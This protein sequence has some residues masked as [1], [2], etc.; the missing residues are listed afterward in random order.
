ML[1][2]LSS[3]PTPLPS[4]R[5]RLYSA[6][7]LR[8]RLYKWKAEMSL[9]RDRE[10]YEGRRSFMCSFCSSDFLMSTNSFFSQQM[11]EAAEL[12]ATCPRP[13][14]CLHAAASSTAP[15]RAA[16][17]VFRIASPITTPTAYSPKN[18]VKE[19]ERFLVAAAHHGADGGGRRGDPQPPSPSRAENEPGAHRRTVRHRPRMRARKMPPT[20]F[21]P[22]PR[23]ASVTPSASHRA[24]PSRSSG[25]RRLLLRLK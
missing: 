9:R 12:P 20:R 4:P 24:E 10:L 18:I 22:P 25:A 11:D 5:G 8:Q 16:A 13:G 19:P 7:L 1:N 6:L 23:P 17:P 3:R 15:C 2:L 21:R 14:R